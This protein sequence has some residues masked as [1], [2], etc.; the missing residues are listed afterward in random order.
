MVELQTLEGRGP[1]DFPTAI[2]AMARNGVGAVLV[3]S[4]GMFGIRPTRIADLAAKGRLP[5]MGTR[6]IV[7]AGVL[8]TYS[9]KGPDL[10]RRAATYV[11]ISKHVGR[12]KILR[13]AK[14]ADLPI[15]QPPAYELVINMKTARPSASRSRPRCWRGRITS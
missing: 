1:D 13:G 3:L 15:E 11:D 5:T 12:V 2:A 7:E 9:A 6:I 4:D 14:P 8:M 10:F